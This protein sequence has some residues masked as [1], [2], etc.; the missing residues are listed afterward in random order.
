MTTYGLKLMSELR[1][2]RG[3]VRQAEMAHDAGLGFVSISD[4]IHPWLSDHDH[5]PF[6]W[7]VLGAIAARVPDLELATGVTCPTG[8]YHPVIVAHAAAT[9]ATMSD[10]RLTL[11][12]GSG[13]RLNEH[14]TGQPFPAI[15]LRLEMLSEAID[16][17]RSLQSGDYITH[18]GAHFTAEDVRLFDL[19]DEPIN[20]V[21]AISGPASLEVARNGADGVM[22]N[23]PVGELLD[24]WTSSGGDAAN[25]WTEVPFAWAPSVDAGLQLAHERF[26]FGASGWKVMSELPN[27]VNFDA[28]TQHVRPE[29]LADSIPHGPDP[30]TYV[31]AL[32]ELIDAGFQRIAIV[33]VGDDTEGLLRFVTD[34]VLPA[35]DD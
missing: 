18:R 17:I 5:S 33:P 31:E 12:L 28:A 25:T 6:A 13:E 9:V 34:E 23:E 20:L 22:S 4:H 24:E 1:D 16:I 35:L 3:L 8:R 10:R 7:S 32:R 19:P 11:A 15:D 2:A 21:M 14:V 27:P 30:G 26:R 29:D